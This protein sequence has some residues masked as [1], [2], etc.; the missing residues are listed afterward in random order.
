MFWIIIVTNS[1]RR[2]APWKGSIRQI[3]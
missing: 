2:K 1:R 3:A